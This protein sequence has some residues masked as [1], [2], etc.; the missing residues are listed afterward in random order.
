MSSSKTKFFV[1]LFAV[2]GLSLAALAPKSLC[3]YYGWPSTAGSWSVPNS[4]ALFGDYDLVVFGAGLEDSSHGDHQN[5]KDIIAHADMS[6]TD[7][8][9]YITA[10]GHTVAQNED[11]IDDWDAMGV[12]CI[13]I[14]EYGYDYGVTRATQNDL[15]E[16]AH[17]LSLFVFVNSWDPDD[18]LDNSV[19]TTY[20]PSGTAHK[21]EATD[22]Y[23][24]ES[25]ATKDNAY[26]DT[27]SDSDG[28]PDWYEKATN[29]A[30]NYLDDIQVATIGT[31]GTSTA[32]FSQAK[33]DYSYYS[34]AMFGFD[35]AG[36]GEK[37]Y[38][39]AG[40]PGSQPFRTRKA[41]PSGDS[42]HGTISKSGNEY[43]VCT[44]VGFA[45]DESA[46]T[47]SDSI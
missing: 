1:L 7:V 40:G 33:W 46:H 13:F 45:V 23:L 27:D 4:A 6:N 17:D 42:I 11:K 21:L 5:T 8:C 30:D 16:Y 2:F 18:A 25:F 9:G 26:D 41:M 32:G 31:T 43:Q 15:V 34:S 19:V 10:A 29:L 36:W 12:D 22:I 35:Y 47:V 39:S 24:A 3:I 28:D 20:N 14:D 44:N 38:G 37:N